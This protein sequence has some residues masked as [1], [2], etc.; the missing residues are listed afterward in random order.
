MR[1]NTMIQIVYEKNGDNYLAQI[2]D[3]F[4]IQLLNSKDNSDYSWSYSFKNRIYV[5][6]SLEGLQAMLEQHMYYEMRI[7]ELEDQIHI[8]TTFKYIM[9]ATSMIR[10]IE[11]SKQLQR[12]LR[13]KWSIT[14]NGFTLNKQGDWEYQSLPSSRTDEYLES[15]EE[16]VKML[17]EHFKKYPKGD[18][19]D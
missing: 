10:Y 5:N 7:K 19:N 14:N 13:P 6:A 15:Y 11:I 9:P 16:A 2:D 17:D 3:K 18:K 4:T 12:D 1:E 8:A